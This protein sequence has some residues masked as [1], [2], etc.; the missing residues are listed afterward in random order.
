[1]SV[2][3]AM[4]S[5]RRMDSLYLSFTDSTSDPT[6]HG[7]W[8][9]HTGMICSSRSKKDKWAKDEETGYTAK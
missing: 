5:F 2:I 7:T 1:M 3:I 6:I 9:T 4:W 8:R